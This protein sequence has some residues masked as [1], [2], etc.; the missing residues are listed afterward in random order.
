MVTQPVKVTEFHGC[1]EQHV[2]INQ[3]A[4]F[5]CPLILGWAIGCRFCQ[6]NPCS[7]T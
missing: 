7:A 3:P 5:H 1:V 2:S 6:V 4:M